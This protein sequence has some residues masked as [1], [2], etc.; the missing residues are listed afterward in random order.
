MGIYLNHGSDR[1]EETIYS[2]IRISKILLLI[3]F[4]VRILVSSCSVYAYEMDEQQLEEYLKQIDEQLDNDYRDEDPATRENIKQQVR[5]IIM[6]SYEPQIEENSESNERQAEEDNGKEIKTVDTKEDFLEWV[7]FQLRDQKEEVYYDTNL[8]ELYNNSKKVFYDIDNY[9]CEDNPLISTSY[10]G[11]YGDQPMNYSW[12]K[13]YVQDE[14]KYRIGITVSYKYTKDEI[15]SHMSDMS[16]L[17]K[18]LQGNTDYESVKAVHDY[19]TEHF[20][21]G[22][23]NGDD[24]IGFREGK[25]DCVGYAMATFAL[26]TN[27]NIPVRIVDGY[28]FV[29]GE[30]YNNCWNIVE[31]DGKWYNLDVSWDDNGEYE[32]R[33]DWFL[34]NNEDFIQHIYGTDQYEIKKMISKTSY[35]VEEGLFIANSENDNQKSVDGQTDNADNM[36]FSDFFSKDFFKKFL[37]SRAG[38]RFIVYI[39]ALLVL[40]IRHRVEEGKIRKDIMTD[41]L[42][43]DI[44]EYNRRNGIELEHLKNNNRKE[45]RK[46]LLNILLMA[47]IFVVLVGI[48]YG[49]AFLIVKCF[50]K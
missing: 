40:I 35:P 41:D 22:D 17:A 25:M 18:E 7:C 33:Y 30:E 10:L 8:N 14:Y 5:D 39:I 26:L 34:R 27:M 6:S 19:L 31:L 21:W 16:N 48:V 23:G 1:F 11:R 38:L 12:G 37:T 32:T 29:D 28:V 49:I 4:V 50:M 47:F 44:A 9:Y 46:M 42:S 43:S 24:I 3:L 45:E 15:Q 2:S 13:K 36:E 20:E